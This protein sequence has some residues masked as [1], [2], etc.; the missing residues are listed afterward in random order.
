MEALVSKGFLLFAQ[1]TPEVN[2][3]SQ[4]YALAL[5]IK[6]TQKEVVNV[7]LITNDTV[8]KKYLR[9]FD[10]IIPIPWF[11]E[12]GTSP[13]AA[14]HRWKFYHVSPYHETMVLDSDMLMLEDIT[15]W[16]KY[17]SNFDIKFCSHIRNYKQEHIPVDKYHRKA[18]IANK[19]SNPYF[20]LHYFKK[21]DTAYNFYKV[22]EFV[23]NNWEAC[24][25]IFAPEYYQKWLSLDLATAIAIEITGIHQEALDIL[26][27]MR[28][29][30][31]KIPLQNWPVG[32]DTWQNAV[33]YVLNDRGELIVGN[34]KQQ[35]LFHYVEKDFMA[36]EIITQLEE[37]NAKV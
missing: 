1:N 31:M 34:I 32:V 13:Y 14:E 28:F 35:R 36:K 37:I 8:P 30:H 3:V 9:V 12:R 20:A 19:L 29:V 7:S 24:Y 11:T 5:S 26:N 15:D 21:S 22:L 16:W 18:F 17:C 33:P 6:N 10:Q 23:C 27:P 2:Y 4:A 25:T